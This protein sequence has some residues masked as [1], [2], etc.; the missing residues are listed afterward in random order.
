MFLLL[1]N[2]IDVGNDFNG[3]TFKV[4]SE[5][6]GDYSGG[7]RSSLSTGGV[8]LGVSPLLTQNHAESLNSNI[9]RAS[10]NATELRQLESRPSN[11][12]ML[13]SLPSQLQ[14][15]RRVGVGESIDG[16]AVGGDYDDMIFHSASLDIIEV[17][18]SMPYYTVSVLTANINMCN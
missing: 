5:D 14:G 15:M 8:A 13:L 18:T 12:P 16:L 1:S 4:S 3:N 6:W 7:P 11:N 17:R 2:S 10:N 9:P